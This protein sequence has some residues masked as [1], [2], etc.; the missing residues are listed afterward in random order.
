MPTRKEDRAPDRGLFLE[1]DIMVSTYDIDFAGHVSNIVYLR[2]FED[3]RLLFFDKYFPLKDFLDEGKTPV[4]ASHHIQYKK[5]IKL[6]DKPHGLMFVTKLGHA[7]MTLRGELRV[8]DQLTTVVEHV[9]VFID[10]A[11]GKPIRVP[12]RCSRIFRERAE[13]IPS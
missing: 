5:P 13:P 6:F 10:L 9:G 1:H 12:E 11:S 2:W 7:T 4:I 8:Q 3:M